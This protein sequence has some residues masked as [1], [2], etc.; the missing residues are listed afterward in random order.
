VDARVVLGGWGSVGLHLDVGLTCSA[1][2]ATA[3]EHARLSADTHA[4][5]VAHC[6]GLCLWPGGG[7]TSARTRVPGLSV[8][9]V[10]CSLPPW[11]PGH[12]GVSPLC[13]AGPPAQGIVHG[14]LTAWNVM[15]CTS[16]DPAA[17][18][19]GRSF[20]A[21]VAGEAGRREVEDE[22]R[23]QRAATPGPL[24]CGALVMCPISVATRLD[25]AATSRVRHVLAR[26]RGPSVP[27]PALSPRT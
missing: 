26:L 6:L 20:V 3:R 10:H 14:D 8:S 16:P 27:G 21:K 25:C 19:S 11:P 22:A 17:D 24:L 18:R 9:P 5:P 13:Y 15:L 7:R 12:G 4:L 1:G 2:L 23:T